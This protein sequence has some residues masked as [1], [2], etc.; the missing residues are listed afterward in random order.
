MQY[1]VVFSPAGWAQGWSAEWWE[2]DEVVGNVS[3]FVNGTVSL[4]SDLFSCDR[5]EVSQNEI[6]TQTLLR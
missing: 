6:S 1:C 4:S 5:P 2:Y 3:N